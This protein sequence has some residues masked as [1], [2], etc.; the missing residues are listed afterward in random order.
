MIDNT[1]FTNQI[2]G[3][4]KLAFID[5]FVN[6]ISS[7]D[8]NKFMSLHKPSSTF[9]NYE[10][11]RWFNILTSSKNDFEY[12]IENAF[13]E[14]MN[15]TL[16]LNLQLAISSIHFPSKILNGSF[17]LVYV[18]NK[19]FIE[20]HKNLT[21]YKKN[22]YN[23][24]IFFEQNLE[25]EAA[26]VLKLYPKIID[27]F[28]H[29]FNV[30]IEHKLISIYLFFSS[31][32]ISFTIPDHSAYGWYESNESIKIF[33]PDFVEDR[34]LFLTKVLIHELT[35]LLLVK[36]SNDNLSLFFQEG[37]AMYVENYVLHDSQNLILSKEQ[38]QTQS[39][40]SLNMLQQ[41][42]LRLHS[43]NALKDLPEES[44]IELYHNGF[45]WVYYLIEKYGVKTFLHFVKSLSKY[46]YL[47]LPT[48]NKFDI[49]NQ[50]TTDMFLKKYSK[51]GFESNDIFTFYND[52]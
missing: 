17:N 45:L 18:D 44:G 48:S 14:C 28:S 43:Y 19:I 22:P 51:E 27:F 41:L 4:I 16:N 3:D 47:N 6:S 26:F 13:I 52:I 24:L 30:E 29:Q 1:T 38:L 40:L 9:F 10:Q 50:R 21:L 31:E 37:F 32:S 20:S 2:T 11:I 7:K 15:D 35:H 42:Q 5:S 34:E 8:L 39:N 25:N 33:I 23:S 12:K 49:I 36:M 46:D